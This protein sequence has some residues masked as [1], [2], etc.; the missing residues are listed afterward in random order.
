MED[1]TVDLFLEQTLEVS[2]QANAPQL[3]V[4]LFNIKTLESR[5]NDARHILD[6]LRI[7][8][9]C[10]E[11]E[12]RPLKALVKGLSHLPA[13]PENRKAMSKGAKR[14]RT[15]R[16]LITDVQSELKSFRKATKTDY[17]VLGVTLDALRHFYD[18]NPEAEAEYFAYLAKVK[19]EEENAALAAA[20]GALKSQD[21]A[22]SNPDQ[23]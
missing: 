23:A 16:G 3:A 4:I 18:N 10:F 13:Y 20:A 7:S 15:L 5:L 8:N 19:E 11:K 12:I 2:K 9:Q 1:I 22:T 17:V 6:D 14:L 21:S